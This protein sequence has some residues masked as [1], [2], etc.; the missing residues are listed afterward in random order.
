LPPVEQPDEAFPFWLTTG[1]VVYHWHTRT[2][3]GRVPALNEAAPEVFIQLSQEDAASYGITEG[4]ML[5]VTSRRGTV[6]GQAR[7]GDIAAGHIFIPFHYGYWD[8]DPDAA[9]ARAAN[10]LTI[11]GWDPV[12][13]QPHFKYAAVRVR[14]L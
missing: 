7:L 14:K 9:R 8:E 4:D 6:H 3:T 13:K 5:E 11:T 12:S 10:E 2:K 1:R